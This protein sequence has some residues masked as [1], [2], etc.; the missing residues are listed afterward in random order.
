MKPLNWKDTLR[1][2]PMVWVTRDRY[3][4]LLHVHG[5]EESAAV[6]LD[7]QLRAGEKGGFTYSLPIYDVE[8]AK[9]RW[10]GKKD[11]L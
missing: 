8:T 7:A 3:G 9:M 5:S 6:E 10:E 2:R 11:G 4:K 1:K